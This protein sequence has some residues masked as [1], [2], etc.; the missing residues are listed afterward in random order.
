MYYGRKGYREDAAVIDQVEG[1]IG[2]L[3]VRTRADLLG[4]EHSQVGGE[5]TEKSKT[6]PRH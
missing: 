1:T 2:K 5:Q 6:L 3:I 4:K